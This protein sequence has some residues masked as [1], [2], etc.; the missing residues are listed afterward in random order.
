MIPFYSQMP[1]SAAIHDAACVAMAA[2]VPKHHRP[3]EPKPKPIMTPLMKRIKR[4]L[5]GEWQTSSEIAKQLN[6]SHTKVNSPLKQ[7]VTLGEAESVQMTRRSDPN[8][9]QWF[10]RRVE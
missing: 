6:V 4:K 3:R 9:L 7:L 5:T 2:S 8:L 1:T 10:Y